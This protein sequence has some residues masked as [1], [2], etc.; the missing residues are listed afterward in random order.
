MSLQAL[1]RVLIKQTSSSIYVH[2]VKCLR[3]CVYIYVFELNT[4]SFKY[5]TIKLIVSIFF[6]H[7]ET[8]LI[9]AFSKTICCLTTVPKPF[10]KF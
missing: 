7:I 6:I 8:F 1:I 5:S 10:A 2:V 3:V 9:K 4:S